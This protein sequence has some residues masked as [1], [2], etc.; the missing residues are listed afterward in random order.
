[1]IYITLASNSNPQGNLDRANETGD[2]KL[3]GN[4]DDLGRTFLYRLLGSNSD[5]VTNS[6]P[7]SDSNPELPNPSF[8][9]T[10][11]TTFSVYVV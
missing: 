6:L 3:V 11:A 5:F 4:F 2:M 7:L 8:T 9:Q 10:S 1:M